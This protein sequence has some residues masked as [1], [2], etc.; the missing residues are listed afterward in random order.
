MSAEPLTPEEIAAIRARDAART[1]GRWTFG[2][3]QLDGGPSGYIYANGVWIGR[4]FPKD[5]LVSDASF[6][7]G[8][9][10]DIPRLLATLDAKDAEIAR[11]TQELEELR[12]RHH[13]PPLP[14]ESQ[15][16]DPDPFV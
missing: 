8:S 15:T 2:G 6:V 9:S 10:E 16:D 1:P 11:L 12:R 13:I 3:G 7:I 14:P 5:G 4:M